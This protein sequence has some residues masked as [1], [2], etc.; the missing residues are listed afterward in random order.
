MAGNNAVAMPKKKSKLSILRNEYPLYIFLLP[1]VLLTLIFAYIPMAL[2]YI[3]F[4]DYKMSSGF[5]G[6]ESPFVGFANFQ[7]FLWD[8]EFWELAFRTLFYSIVLTITGFPSPILLAILLNELRFMTFKK[9]VQTI[10]YLPHFISWVTVAALVYIFLTVDTEGVI[11]NVRE[12]F[13]FERYSYMKYAG[14]FVW[15]ISITSI[16]KETGWGSI[17]YLA[18]ISS[19]DAQLFEAAKID[20]AGRLQQLWHI[21]LPSIKPTIMIL[22]ILSMGSLFAT[23]FDMIYALQNDVIRVDTNVI[24]TY[25][26]TRGI[27]GSEKA[28]VTAVSLFQGAINAILLIS[29]NYISK[30]LTESGLF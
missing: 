26:Y 9:T 13:G 6:L 20:G 28:K 7:K 23:G 27:M 19:I 30:R 5:L 2:N 14:N 24:A 10:T 3:A 25:V 8:K 22:F 21:T 17:I 18:A 11:N 16:L 29:T 12:F 1:A 15:V 4:T